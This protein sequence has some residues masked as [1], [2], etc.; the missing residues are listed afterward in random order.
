MEVT[1]RM[2]RNGLRFGLNREEV[3]NLHNSHVRIQ[4]NPRAEVLAALLQPPTRIVQR[5]STDIRL[6]ALRP[7]PNVSN[8]PNLPNLPNVPAVIAARRNSMSSTRDFSHNVTSR[9]EQLQQY[10]LQQL[11]NLDEDDVDD[12]NGQGNADEQENGS[13]QKNGIS[14]NDGIQNVSNKMVYLV[15]F[16]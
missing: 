13:E 2:T 15:F 11:L 12:F 14:N 1:R 3:Y 9:A 5:H 10:G 16:G 6:P 8:V 7:S 4:V